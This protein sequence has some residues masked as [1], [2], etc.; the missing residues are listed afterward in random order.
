MIMSAINLQ[1]VRRLVRFSTLLRALWLAMAL[2]HVWLIARRL[3]LGELGGLLELTRGA[4]C[5]AGVAYCS[6]KFWRV[7]TFFDSQPRRAIAFGLALLVGHV[8]IAPPGTQSLLDPTGMQLTTVL[9][10]APLLLALGLVA[11]AGRRRR[12]GPIAWRLEP[13]SGRTNEPLP[14]RLFQLSP[15]LHR[16]PP[17]RRA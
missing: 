5:L 17:P 13:A 4:L 16:R 1:A 15:S 6:L 14:I 8:L 3:W 10:T 2:L 12:Q 9:V 11:A 7:A